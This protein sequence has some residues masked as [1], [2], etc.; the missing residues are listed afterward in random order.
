MRGRS[1]GEEEGKPEDIEPLAK[2]LYWEEFASAWGKV[3]EAWQVASIRRV[4]C[5]G[6]RPGAYEWLRRRGSSLEFCPS[7]ARPLSE[8]T[9]PGGL[10]PN[11]SLMCR[12][13]VGE[14]PSFNTSMPVSMKCCVPA[15][16]LA[17]ELTLPDGHSAKVTPQ[18]VYAPVAIGGFLRIIA[19]G[20]RKAHNMPGEE[21]ARDRVIGCRRLQ[22][23]VFLIS[24]RN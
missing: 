9:T 17:S 10:C 6:K 13:C 1:K 21:T 12:V 23:L 16:G 22:P 20:M 19:R 3:R 8:P 24:N 14:E 11:K 18:R 4:R 7:C 5:C 15:R 2:D